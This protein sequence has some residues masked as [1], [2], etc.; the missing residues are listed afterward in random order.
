MSNIY[1][2]HQKILWGVVPLWCYFTSTHADTFPCESHF[3]RAIQ[4]NTVPECNEAKTHLPNSRN[5][6]DQ[7]FNFEL[8]THA[9]GHDNLG[10]IKLQRHNHP[11]KVIYRSGVLS[12]SPLCLKNLAKIGQIKTIV[13][14]LSSE[15]GYEKEQGKLEESIF[16]DLGGQNYIQILNFHISTHST[17]VDQEL[18]QRIKDI[19]LQIINLNGNV[20]VHCIIGEHNTGVI[21][22]VIEKCYQHLPMDD[23]AKSTRCHIGSINAEYNRFALAKVEKI[24]ASF[25]CSLLQEPASPS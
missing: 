3:P 8:Y 17:K 18:F 21:M 16:N 7:S 15:Y 1:P 12:S 6:L 23:I 9:L 22:G 25:P 19:I 14:L 13:N 5:Q 10:G 2:L 24:I 4:V 20:L 11:P